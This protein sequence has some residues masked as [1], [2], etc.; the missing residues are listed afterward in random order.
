[1]NKKPFAVFKLMHRIMAIGQLLF[2]AI[3]FFLVYSK[4]TIPPLT[5]E[6]KTFQ[7]V[8]IVLSA[9]AFFAGNNLF[10]KKINE[11]GDAA[12]P[13]KEKFERYRSACILQW[14]LLEGAILFSGTCFFLTGNYAFLALGGMLILLF[15]LQAPNKT[16][17]ALQTGMSLAEAEDL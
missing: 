14:A 4:T 6:D 16:K 1:M 10:K 9:A 2:L 17:M 8:A 15:L 13:L 5:E 12:L 7:V 3:M 11:I